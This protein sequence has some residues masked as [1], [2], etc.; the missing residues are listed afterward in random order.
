MRRIFHLSVP[1]AHLEKACDFY[2]RYLGAT[3]GRITADWADILLWG[4]QITLQQRPDEVLPLSE[5]GKRHFGVVL[6]WPEWEALGTKL[7]LFGVEFLAP[8]EIFFESTP[9]EQAKLCIEDPS[10]NVIEIKAYRD[11][12]GVLGSED[13]TYNDDA[14]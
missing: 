7:D 10:H 4:H 6:P 9:D 2:Q 13:T 14:T 1:V 12:A 3:V 8:P 11:F 5:Q